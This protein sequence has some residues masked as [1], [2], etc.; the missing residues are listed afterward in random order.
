MEQQSQNIKHNNYNDIE[1][2]KQ[3]Q[4][5]KDV[6]VS[7]ERLLSGHASIKQRLEAMDNINMKLEELDISSDYGKVLLSC[8]TE[9]ILHQDYIYRDFAVR[10]KAI[11]Q[12]SDVFIYCL[13]RIHFQDISILV[14][15]SLPEILDALYK[16]MDDNRA[17]K[18]H[19]MCKQ[20]II[21]NN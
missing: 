13:N 14:D 15:Q 10:I 9:Q 1:Q 8:Y 18:F 17:R 3:R 21:K 7:F 16:L 4:D 12:I 20:C 2:K 19:E 6:N 11:Q 5:P